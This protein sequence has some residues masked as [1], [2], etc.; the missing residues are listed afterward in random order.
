MTDFTLL[1]ASSS[2]QDKLITDLDLKIKKKEDLIEFKVQNNVTQLQTSLG[3][4]KSETENHL[5]TL[6]N[7]EKFQKELSTLNLKLETKINKVDSEVQ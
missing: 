5:K 3:T 1:S 2:N 6:I 7:E 4:L